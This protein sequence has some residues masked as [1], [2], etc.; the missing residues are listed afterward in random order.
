MKDQ[1]YIIG[2][3]NPDTDSICSAIAYAEFKNK[4][5]NKKAVPYRLG[6]LN[7]ETKFILDYFDVEP[8]QLLKTV[9]TQVSDLNI[10]KVAPV[11]P[12]IS[13]K[14]AWSLMKKQ[15]I[16]TLPVVDAN[17]KLCGV[18]SV[19][20]ITTSY[21]DIWDSNIISKSHTSL[22]NILDTL[23]AKR[24]YI[25]P[26]VS[27]FTGKIMVAAM[28]P[29]SM[30]EMIEK[31]DIV[32]CGNRED[33]QLLIVEQKAT[34]L[35]I[36]GNH[37]VNDKI[38]DLAKKNGCSVI[39]T[40]YDT[41]TTSKLITQSIP[42]S[43]VMTKKNII[44]FRTDDFVEEIKDIMLETRYRSYPVLDED[45]KVIG[46]IS[47]YHLIS[48]NKK[49]VILMDHNEKMQSV[50]G[51]HDAD[52][53]EIIDHH[54][55][56]DVETGL[57]IY[58]RNEPVGSTSTIVGSIFFENGIRPSKKTSSLLCAAIISD[59]L[60]LKSP[61]ATSIDEFILKRLA[62]IA[63]INVDEFAKE[64]FKAGTSLEG[65]TPEEIFYQDFKT[66]NL[67][68]LKVGVS[69]VSTL[70][71]EGFNPQKEA[72]IELMKQEAKNQGY[73]LIVLMVTDIL[74]TGSELIGV[75]E[76]RDLIGKAFN[77]TLKNHSA[78]IPDVVSRKKQIIPP[79]TKA[80]NT[81]ATK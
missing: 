15:E 79:L 54:R 66:F 36:T 76:Y 30:T 40:P 20:N 59:T 73:D 42:L 51:L 39:S 7:R 70:Y 5:G 53:V 72:V 65:K 52:V 4:T 78:Y 19:S 23:S 13:L 25:N 44:S 68:P 69:Q 62:K 46:A 27:K 2:H 33:S 43:H 61:T 21:M 22:D 47:R 8:P 10:D 26:N 32:I 50:N 55:I 17:D 29:E 9:K 75:G 64:M 80:I 35:I 57:P 58:F 38:L 16:I 48:E 6:S 45:N 74:N 60:L 63:D 3:K 49:K 24:I 1:L 31:C 18:A 67:T 34:L 37:S 71:L 11:S 28:K 77:V 81:F 12:D 41:F 56:A 14:M